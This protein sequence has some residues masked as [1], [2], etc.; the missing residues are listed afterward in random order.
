M[1]ASLL[2]GLF[3]SA[4]TSA[5]L[6]PGTSEAVLAG[7]VAAGSVP[8]LALVLVASVGNVLGSCVNWWLGKQAARFGAKAAG[9]GTPP[10]RVARAQAFY[11]RYGYWSLL[12]SW[13]PVIGDPLTVI[14]GL[15]R[16]PFWRFVAI[17]AI[18]KTGRYAVLAAGLAAAGL[19][20]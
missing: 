11:H 1:T 13:V 18:A 5:T 16:E 4:F 3:L 20:G 17:V 9:G 15:M 12:A 8:L 7:L 14:A 2:A 6:L 19:Q 10:A